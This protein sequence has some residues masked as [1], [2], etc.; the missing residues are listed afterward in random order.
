[1]MISSRSSHAS[2]ALCVRS[3]GSLTSSRSTHAES[4]SSIDGSI[5]L[6]GGIGSLTWRRRIAIGASESLNGTRPVNSSNAMQP[7]E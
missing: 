1:M 5:V 7:T 6:I 4:P 2:V 3:L